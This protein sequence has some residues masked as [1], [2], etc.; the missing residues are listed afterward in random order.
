MLRSNHRE[1]EKEYKLTPEI[2]MSL[3]T[4]RT[5]LSLYLINYV[6]TLTVTSYTPYPLRIYINFGRTRV[7]T[8]TSTMVS[9]AIYPRSE[10]TV[11]EIS[12]DGPSS[13]SPCAQWF[14]K[15]GKYI[16]ASLVAGLSLALILALGLTLTTLSS[17]EMAT[18]NT[19]LLGRRKQTIY[20]F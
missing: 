20:V 17:A 4:G 9:G 7:E 14:R 18:A 6:V 1:V 19:T 8:T 2:S 11:T 5:A 15:Y 16:L 10:T 3:S 12:L 13:S